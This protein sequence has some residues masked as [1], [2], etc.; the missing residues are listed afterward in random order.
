MGRRDQT[1]I[2]YGDGIL[3][4]GVLSELKCVL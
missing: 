4:V 2:G 3:L 1:E